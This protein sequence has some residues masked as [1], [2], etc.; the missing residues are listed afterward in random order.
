MCKRK[1]DEGLQCFDPLKKVLFVDRTVLQK[2][3]T[4]D[5]PVFQWHMGQV[6]SFA[7]VEIVRILGKTQTNKKV[8]LNRD[9]KKNS[10]YI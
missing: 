5:L 8:K 1:N 7:V 6:F 9:L 3:R 10:I 4:C 2:H